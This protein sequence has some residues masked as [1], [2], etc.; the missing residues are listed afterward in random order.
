[1]LIHTES[2]TARVPQTPATTQSFAVLPA[3]PHPPEKRGL[4][5]AII[6]FFD[7]LVPLGYEDEAGFHAGCEPSTNARHRSALREN[8]VQPNLAS[9]R[10]V[11]Q[12]HTCTA[13]M[14][15]ENEYEADAPVEQL[16]VNEDF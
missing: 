2:T 3:A 7:A 8:A 10:V 14:P 9:W 13:T 4:L 11:Q 6:G 1:M 15:L 5:A 12:S 16:W